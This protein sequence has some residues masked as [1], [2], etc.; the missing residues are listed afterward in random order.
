MFVVSVAG[1][2]YS[3]SFFFFF[4]LRDVNILHIVVALGA[5]QTTD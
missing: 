5:R 1:Y 4:F 2:F 3:R